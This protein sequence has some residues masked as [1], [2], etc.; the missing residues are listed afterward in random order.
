MAEGRVFAHASVAFDDHEAGDLLAG[1]VATLARRQRGEVKYADFDS[2]QGVSILAEALEEGGPLHARAS[3]YLVDKVYMT[4]GEAVDLLVE[5]AANE[6]GQDLYANGLARKMAHGL[7]R[8]GRRALGP[9]G[10]DALLRGLVSLFRMPR[11]GDPDPVERLETFFQLVDQLR[12]TCRRRRV[13]ELLNGFIQAR[14]HA[15]KFQAELAQSDRDDFLPSLDPL[16]ATLPQVVRSWSEKFGS[17]RYLHD[18]VNV[19]SDGRINL[20]LGLLRHPESHSRRFAYAVRIGDF[21]R[22]D[23]KEPASIQLADV[24]A[25]AGRSAGLAALAPSRTAANDAVI[26]LVRPLVHIDSLW[27]D[28]PSWRLLTGRLAVG[29]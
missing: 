7:F 22:G 4:A 20:L 29:R 5:E 25:G 6:R 24:L 8:E 1:L 11:P 23:S 13:D 9:E 21:V 2:A 16:I 14:H 19:L 27:G 12:V 15:E 17:A 18:R 26:G 3:V 28:D 10:F